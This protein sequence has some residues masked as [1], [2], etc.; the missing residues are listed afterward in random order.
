MY[1]QCTRKELILLSITRMVSINRDE[2]SFC[3]R[4]SEAGKS[5]H[6][7]KGIKSNNLYFLSQIR[8]KLVVSGLKLPIFWAFLLKESYW[9]YPSG[10][11]LPRLC[12]P[13]STNL[14]SIS[15]LISS[16][17]FSAFFNFRFV[18]LSSRS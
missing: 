1:L 6:F 16:F 15:N 12:H 5:G 18:S 13:E 8:L 14:L 10:L 17:S 2:A 4:M 3:R 9:P 11:G 7:P